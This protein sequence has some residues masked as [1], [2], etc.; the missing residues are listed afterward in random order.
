MDI[1]ET[2]TQTEIERSLPNIR[3]VFDI[4]NRISD[5]STEVCTRSWTPTILRQNL[6]LY[7]V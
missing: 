2:E 7:P 3:V 1:I 6:G 4:V 5:T